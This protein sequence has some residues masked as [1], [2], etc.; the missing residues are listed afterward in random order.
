[1]SGSKPASPRGPERKRR[2]GG[3]D[4][5]PVLPT[6]AAEDTGH[7]WGEADED[8]DERITRERPPHWD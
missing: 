3:T 6:R 1:M 8:D 7:A 5:E 2:A 4:D